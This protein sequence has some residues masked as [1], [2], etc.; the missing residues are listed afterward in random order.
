MENNRTLKFLNMKKK[1]PNSLF[2]LM[3][4]RRPLMAVFVACMA[5]N[6]VW[7]QE[8]SSWVGEPLPAEGGEFYLYNKEGGGFLLG[9]NTWG[10]QASLGQPGLLCTLEVMPDG[11]YAIKTTANNI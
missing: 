6:G 10:T 5:A 4:K 1:I 3:G 9:A 8:E 2:P 11:K 7:A